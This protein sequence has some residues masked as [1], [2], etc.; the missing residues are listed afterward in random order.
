MAEPT[1]SLKHSVHVCVCQVMCTV[2]LG[3]ERGNMKLSK[4]L[5]LKSKMTT[6]EMIGWAWYFYS[7]RKRIEDS[8]LVL[9]SRYGAGS[10]AVMIAHEMRT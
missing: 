2:I 1:A 7:M 9:K 6:P 8:G 10:T 3:L 4:Y 5:P